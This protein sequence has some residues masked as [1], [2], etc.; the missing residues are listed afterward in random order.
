MSLSRKIKG[1]LRNF[2]EA[3]KFDDLLPAITMISSNHRN[4]HDGF[5][6]HAVYRA[7]GLA[8]LASLEI[9]YAPPTGN[10]PHVQGMYLT[11]GNTPCDIKNYYGTTTSADGTTIP[12]FNRN[13]NSSNTANLVVTHTP[14]ITADGTLF[15]DRL[16]PSPAKDAGI[17]TPDLGEEWLLAPGQKYLTR[18]TNNSGGPIDLTF[19]LLWYEPGY[20]KQ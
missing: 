2:E 14:T 6:F 5:F 4:V 16:V 9:L 19:E 1:L 18:I 12:S 10:Y 15:H 20:A 17:V 7:T 8:A 3:N 13:F 11:V